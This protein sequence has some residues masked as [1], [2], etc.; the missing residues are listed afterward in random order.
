[1]FIL[2]RLKKAIRLMADLVQQQVTRKSG[3]GASLTGK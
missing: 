2:V 3:F 1:M